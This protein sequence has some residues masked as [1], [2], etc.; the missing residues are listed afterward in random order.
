MDGRSG[1][2]VVGFSEAFVG[3]GGRDG[4]GV[5]GVGYISVADC[6]LDCMR[7]RPDLNFDSDWKSG[8]Q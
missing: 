4:G 2:A 6:D 1:G 5:C 8:T 3:V 7:S